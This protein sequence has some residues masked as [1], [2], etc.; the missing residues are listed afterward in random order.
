MDNVVKTYLWTLG[1]VTAIPAFEA[2][3]AVARLQRQARYFDVLDA[4]FVIFALAGMW[5][6]FR[7]LTRKLDKAIGPDGA[8]RLML[9]AWRIAVFGAIG[10][11]IAT[12]HLR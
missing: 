5:L 11:L 3:L 1:F 7:Q 6:S 12:R 9:P 2:L 8:R 4:V 10:L